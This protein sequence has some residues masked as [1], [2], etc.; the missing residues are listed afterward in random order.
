M[1]RR[2]FYTWYSMWFPPTKTE[3]G[4]VGICP[5]RAEAETFHSQSGVVVFVVEVFPGDRTFPNIVV[6]F[7]AFLDLLGPAARAPQLARSKHTMETGLN[8]LSERY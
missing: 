7:W 4:R 3:R 8:H 5:C 1:Q 2:L 6:I